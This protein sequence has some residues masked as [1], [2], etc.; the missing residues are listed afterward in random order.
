M[1]LLEF[2][3]QHAGVAVLDP[4]AM[5]QLQALVPPA[6]AARPDLQRVLELNIQR[7]S[8]LNP[9]PL[10]FWTAARG[11][12]QPLSHEQVRALIQLLMLQ[13]FCSKICLRCFFS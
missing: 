4:P 7:C 6:L 3:W 13:V 9:I 2:L 11:F 5:A 12:V 8:D 1:A 10:F